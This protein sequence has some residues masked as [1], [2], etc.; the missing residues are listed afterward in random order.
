MTPAKPASAPQFPP[1][2][3]S[4]WP[5]P[6]QCPACSRHAAYA[7]GQLTVCVSRQCDPRGRLWLDLDRWYRRQAGKEPMQ[8][9]TGDEAVTARRRAMA[10]LKARK[11]RQRPGRIA[12]ANAAVS[13]LRDQNDR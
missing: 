3:V 7:I 10:H 11:P 4:H 9:D 5:Q 13:R 6:S 1:L 12:A 2:D 8:F